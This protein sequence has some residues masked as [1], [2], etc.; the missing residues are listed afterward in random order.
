MNVVEFLQ[1]YT[2]GELPDTVFQWIL[3]EILEY[4]VETGRVVS[5]EAML[6][7]IEYEYAGHEVVLVVDLKQVNPGE[8]CEVREIIF[9]GNTI[10]EVKM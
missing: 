8:V 6:L 10:R 2:G 3:D 1:N 9:D 7:Y 4:G 5:E